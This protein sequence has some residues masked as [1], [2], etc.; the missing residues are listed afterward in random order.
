MNLVF[1][2]Y[3]LHVCLDQKEQPDFNELDWLTDISYFGEQ[4]CPEVLSAAEVPQL[5]TSQPSNMISFRQPKSYS[6]HKK[7]RIE[8]PDDDEEFFTVPDLG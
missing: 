5:P 6:P 8:V 3:R 7:P 1:H 4:V 2:S